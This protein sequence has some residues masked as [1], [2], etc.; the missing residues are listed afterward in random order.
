[1]LVKLTRWILDDVE[2]WASREATILS[3]WISNE[4]SFDATTTLSG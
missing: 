4:A 1:M 3:R 2:E